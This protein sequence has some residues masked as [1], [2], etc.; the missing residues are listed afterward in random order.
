M[1]TFADLGVATDIVETL[2]RQHIVKP[3]PIQALAIPLAMKGHDLIGQA[4]TGTGKTMG[5]TIP[6]VAADRLSQRVR[7]AAGARRRTDP[8]AGSPG[9][10]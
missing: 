10:A 3:F 6:P 8:R 5:F 4:R 1:K 9:R 2:A 7:Q